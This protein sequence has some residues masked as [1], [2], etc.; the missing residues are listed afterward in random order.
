MK[1]KKKLTRKQFLKQEDEFISGSVKTLNW[2]KEN[3]NKIVISAIIFFIILIVV[4]SVRY[5]RKTNLIKSNRFLSMA[6]Q[7]YYSKV[8]PPSQDP[9]IPMSPQEFSSSEERVAASLRQTHSKASGKSLQKRLD[10]EEV[11]V[12]LRASI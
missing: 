3:Y 4:L 12:K 5:N 11:P 1:I 6:K 8:R 2:I 7:T 9:N 10:K